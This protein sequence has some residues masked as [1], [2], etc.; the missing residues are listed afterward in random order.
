MKKYYIIYLC[1]YCLFCT[2]TVN[3]NISICYFKWQMNITYWILICSEK[4][5]PLTE[6]MNNR[7]TVTTFRKYTN[8]V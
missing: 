8:N 2:R 5:E 7:L 4:N 6:F 3:T 1:N